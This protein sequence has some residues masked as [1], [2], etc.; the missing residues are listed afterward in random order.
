MPTV[1]TS[2]HFYLSLD[3]VPLATPAWRLTNLQ[4]L[5]LVSADVRGEDR[6]VPFSPGAIPYPRVVTV[7]RHSL[8]L[9]ISG[10]RDHEDAAYAD[11]LDGWVTNVRYLHDNVIAPVD[12]GGGTRTAVIHLTNS[13]TDVETTW[14][15]EV[16]VERLTSGRRIAPTEWTA[17]LE[18]SVPGG[19]FVLDEVEE[20]PE[21]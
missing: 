4:D 6:V 20:E 12:S 19:V 17:S 5:I 18:L 11:P 1:N 8:L 16:H 14:S 10:D 3:D 7:T 21:P 2:P 13:D 15:A 9:L